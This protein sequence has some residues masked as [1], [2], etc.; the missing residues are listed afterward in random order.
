MPTTLEDRRR[1][2][3]VDDDEALLEMLGQLFTN[4][5]KGHWQVHLAST[6]AKALAIL[7]EH[8]ITLAVLDI[9]MPV[10]DGQQFLN[11]IHRRYPGLQKVVLT[12]FANEDYRT[13]CLRGGA[14]LF[15]EKPRTPDGFETVFA[16]LNEL[17]SW[18]PQEGFRG[19]LRQVGLQ[20]VL[21]MECLGRNSSLL[22]VSTA[23]ARG[24]ISI[25]NGSIIHA[26]AG[27]KTGEDALN[28]LLALRGGEFNLK[29]FVEP[30]KA[31][32]EGQWE[33]L[34]MEAARRRDEAAI[35]PTAPDEGATAFI[36]A[37]SI[38]ALEPEPPP[39]RAN[40][41]DFAP[42]PTPARAARPRAPSPP[43]A[44]RIDEVLVCSAQ[45]DVLYEWQSP[46]L[47]TRLKFFQLISEKAEQFAQALPLGRFDR[48]EITGPN[49]RIVTQ[50]QS[51]RKLLV[52]S[53]PALPP[54]ADF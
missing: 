24:L 43:A 18:Q 47:E 6:S 2:L 30:A 44:R 39:A 12:G 8:R 19:L 33:F 31:T 35:P 48:L 14:E 13:A 32:I 38:P 36:S 42:P 25:K 40:T 37:P 10:V 29:P 1:I 16:T 21:Q 23:K 46:G 53:S 20:D 51:G 41:P 27:E 50:I 3:F 49:G 11:L 22:E 15:L 34:L 4:W 26:E 17:A 52:R 9:Q 28:F 54:G 5:S 7:Q 45:N